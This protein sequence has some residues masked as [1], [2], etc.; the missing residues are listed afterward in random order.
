LKGILFGSKMSVV[1]VDA[2][3]S[4]RKKG[5]QALFLLL[6]FII[7]VLVIGGVDTAQAYTGVVWTQA[8]PT[9]NAGF[10]GRIDHTSVVFA[11]KMW[12]IGGSDGTVI[13]DVGIYSH[14]VWYSTNGA[15]WTQATPSAAFSP[16][17][18]HTSVVFKKKMWVIGG[19]DN[20]N[21][22]Y[23]DTWSSSNGADWT[24][25]TE[26]A[27]FPA[28]IDHTSVVFKNETG[29]KMW[30]IGGGDG[31]GMYFNDVW[32][33]A[34]GAD[35]TQATPSA[36]F[37]PRAYHTSVVFDN[38]MWVIGGVEID[39]TYLTDVWYSTN[40]ADWTQ[41]PPLAAFPPRAFHTSVVFDNKMW[42]I[43]GDVI[44]GTDDI[45]G[46]YYN[47]SWF[48]RDGATWTEAPASVPPGQ[49]LP[50]R[51]Y[52]TSVVFDNKMWVIGGDSGTITSDGRSLFF[53]DVWYCIF[54]PNQQPILNDPGDQQI[55]EGKTLT[56]ELSASDDDDELTYTFT[57]VP[58]MDGAT[59]S[60]NTFTWT[61][62]T[63]TAGTYSVT[64][65]VTDPE[66]LSDELEI[67][68][69][70]TK[71]AE[72]L[73]VK[74]KI[75]P[76][77]LNLGCRGGVFVAFV[78][79]PKEYTANEV[80]KKSITCGGAPAERIIKCKWFPHSFGVIFNRNKLKNV[81]EGDKVTL[82]LT[83]QLKHAG[84]VL[85]F[86]GSDTVRILNK[87]TKNKDEIDNV[88]TLSDDKIYERHYR[89][90]QFF[91]NRE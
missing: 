11:N 88:L 70:V 53:N 50:A 44:V 73:P 18:Y 40:G 27:A 71:F 19:V 7:A 86:E 4:I 24:L 85:D 38:K 82:T 2:G 69:T 45:E 43:G 35:W 75:V 60:G 13:D 1:H 63:G 76:D 83:G 6:M 23:N 84:Q 32:Y 89:P 39:G 30:V 20:S 64:F 55:A 80:I 22:Y 46:T 79:L 66:G 54:H 61:P 90:S 67:T 51:S 33:S 5:R 37:S 59:I 36:A 41:A 57:S 62:V 77:T 56:I 34:N 28:R 31:N 42:V 72:K 48:S 78:Q 47:D 91:N 15:D 17:V 9:D 68:I 52:H 25:V 3:D 87:Y 65:G 12:V 26:T 21:N 81:P 8:K 29:E 58:S 49:M 74:I 16:R 14:D 10:S